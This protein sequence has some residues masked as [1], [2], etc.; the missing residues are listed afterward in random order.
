MD[1]AKEAERELFLA[2]S[3]SDR[4]NH[5]QR[6]QVYATL[7]SKGETRI[8]Q[9]AGS[10]VIYCPGGKHEDSAEESFT[11]AEMIRAGKELDSGGWTN[12]LTRI[13]NQVR[14]NR[15][16]DTHNK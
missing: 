14:K 4:A 12:T 5:L 9:G 2:E 15:I 1:Y 11:L 16:Y 7:A 6:A 8:S 3:G 13:T 10:R